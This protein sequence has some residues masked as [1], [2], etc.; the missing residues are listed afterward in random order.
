MAKLRDGHTP[1]NIPYDA[2]VLTQDDEVADSK[3]LKRTAN[4]LAV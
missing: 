4:A 3:R 2:R 1:Y